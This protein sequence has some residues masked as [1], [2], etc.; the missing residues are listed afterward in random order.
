MYLFKKKMS[1]PTCPG[2]KIYIKNTIKYDGNNLQLVP[3]DEI[4]LQKQLDS[5]KDCCSLRHYLEKFGV[6]ALGRAK[7]AEF[8]KKTGTYA[9]VSVY[10]SSLLEAHRLGSS[11]RASAELIKKNFSKTGKEEVLDPSSHGEAL[12][13]QNSENGKENDK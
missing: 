4:D 12:S 3:T 11:A 2:C 10:P 9:D 5:Y 8:L 1:K 13:S 6:D 7:T